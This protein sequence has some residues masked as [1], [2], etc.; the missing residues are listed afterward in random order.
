MENDEKRRIT[1]YTWISVQNK[2]NQNV[3]IAPMVVWTRNGRGN[4]KRNRSSYKMKTDNG[5][6]RRKRWLDGIKED[7]GRNGKHRLGK[8]CWRQ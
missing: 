3:G 1:G 4:G 2:F 6:R 5:W 7:T 8:M